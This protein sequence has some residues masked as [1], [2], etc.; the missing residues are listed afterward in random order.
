MNNGKRKPRRRG[1]IAKSP[2][3]CVVVH[4]PSGA[5]MSDAVAARIINSVTEIAL[6][7]G[8]LINFTR[9]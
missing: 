3:V 1:Y 6:E 2:A 4:N 5:P 9:T 8:C 7:E